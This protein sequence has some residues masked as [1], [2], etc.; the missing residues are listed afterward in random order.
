V[1]ALSQYTPIRFAAL[2]PREL[3]LLVTRYHDILIMVSAF[4][5]A[6]VIVM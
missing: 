5:E 6:P 4:D 1:R 3:L 2:C